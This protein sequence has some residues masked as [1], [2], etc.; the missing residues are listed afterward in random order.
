MDIRRAAPIAALAAVG[1]ALA[2]C[3][4]GNSE[5]QSEGD[6]R[7]QT[8]SVS[9]SEGTYTNQ[10]RESLPEFE[11]ETG[12]TVE[13][14]VLGLDQLSNQYQ[15]KLNAQS[16]DLDVMFFRPLQEARLFEDNGWLVDLTDQ[17]AEDADFGWD[18][19][20]ASS[21]QSVTVDDSVYGVPAMTEREILFYNT[22]LFAEAGIEVPTTTEEL[23]A[24]AKKLHDPANGRFGI[25]LRGQLSAAVTTFS[26][27]LYSFGGDWVDESGNAAIDSKEA[28]AAYEYY[29]GLLRNYGP[30]GASSIDGAQARAIFQNGQAAMYIDPDSGAGLLEDPT[31]SQI[32]GKVGYAPFPTGPEGMHPYDVTSW[33]AGISEYSEKKAASWEFIKWATSSGVLDAAMQNQKSP[34]PRSSSWEDPEVASGFSQELTDIFSQYEGE[35]VG[36]DR[37]SVIEVGKVRDIVGA[38]IIA[39]INGEDVAAAAKQANESFQEYLD[40]E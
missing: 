25:A 15:V 4:A 32:A 1:L 21:V 31:E 39:A 27:F 14:N 20:T 34:S 40:S 24:A 23:E 22:E 28:I 17:V 29:G 5:E 13:L 9:L 8:V 35:A 38:P 30:S 12:I 33:A 26:G 10:L 19:F 18:D 16:A 6:L 3:S 7:G 36:R 11:E 2:G 37:P